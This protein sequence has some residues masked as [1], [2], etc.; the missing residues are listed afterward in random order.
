MKYLNLAA[1]FLKIV[2]LFSLIFSILD[3][4]NLERLMSHLVFC[5]VVLNISK[6]ILFKLHEFYICNHMNLMIKKGCV[7]LLLPNICPLACLSLCRMNEYYATKKR[8]L[9]EEN[10][11]KEKYCVKISFIIF[12]GLCVIFFPII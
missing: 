11:M 3:L 4:N 9:S 8:Q 12:F 6:R 7:I 5:L 2:D 10:V 1:N